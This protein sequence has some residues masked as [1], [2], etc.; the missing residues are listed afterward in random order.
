VPEPH[1]KS[2]WR[3]VAPC[4]PDQ[5]TYCLSLK[6]HSPPVLRFS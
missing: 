5:L 3:R 6:E 1:R 2:K 4:L